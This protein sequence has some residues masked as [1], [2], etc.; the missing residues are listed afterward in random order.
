MVETGWKRDRK[1]RQGC[2]V[3]VGGRD[4]TFYNAVDC[5]NGGEQ[6]FIVI[7]PATLHSPCVRC[8]AALHRGPAAWV[9]VGWLLLVAGFGFAQ[10]A[11]PL[12]P[13]VPLLVA[14]TEA[15]AGTT[16]VLVSA[17]RRAQELG[18]SSVA[19][20]LYQR[21]LAEP[22]ADRATLALGLA[23]ALIES[24]RPDDAEKAL[25]DSPAPRGSAWHLRVG[26]AA[27]QLRKYDVAR[28][29]AALVKEEELAADDRPWHLFLQGALFDVAP[30]QD[31]QRA[32]D[33]YNRAEAAATNELA[34]ARFQLAAEE[35]RLR[36]GTVKAEDLKR[37]LDSYEA[38]QGR[39]IGYPYAMSYAMSLDALGRN[40]EAQTF[41]QLVLATLPAQERD[42]WDKVRLVLGLVGGRGQS[43]AARR[44]LNELL[45]GGHDPL[46]QRQALQILSEASKVEPG[47]S[48][49]RIELDRLISSAPTHAIRESLLFYRAQLALM[50]KNDAKVIECATALL[51][52]FPTS[53]LR[54]H[55]Y[56]LLTQLAW[57]Q[58]RYRLAAD[59]ARKARAEMATAG[60]P[61][62][63]A[64]RAG[65]A[66]VEAEAWFRAGMNDGDKNMFRNAAEAYAVALRERPTN[67]NGG[68][69]MFQ[70]VLAE[71]KSGSPDAAKVL[72]EL[73]ND[74]AFDLENRWQAE[75]S[76][77]RA[78]QVQGRV[79]EAYAR[80]NALLG[81]AA[82]GGQPVPVKPDLRVRMAWLQARLSLQA[83]QPETTLSL[84]DLLLNTTDG[85]PSALR[86]E[87][88]S[89]ALLQKAGAQFELGREVP[90]LE[91]LA[92]VR[93]NFP[94][95]EA[96]IHS[97]LIEADYYADQGKIVE[98]QKRLTSLTD[99]ESYK[100]NRLIPYAYYQLALWSERLGQNKDFQDAYR[101]IENLVSTSAAEKEGDFVFV[102]RLKQAELLRRL[103]QFPQAQRVYDDLTNKP[104]STENGIIARLELAK[105]HNAQAS[106]DPSHGD[107][108]KLLF[109]ELRDRVDAPKDV[110]V[111]A[112]YHLA[113][114]LAGRGKLDDAV[115]VWWADV[116][117]PYLVEE[118][119][120]FEPAA[121]RPY[122]LARTLLDLGLL[123]EQQGKL[124]EAR[125]AYD[126]IL[127]SK[128]GSGEEL[129]KKGLERMGGRSG[130]R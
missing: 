32:N 123:L 22:D 99:D 69:L 51:E 82:A 58:H 68:D 52:Q 28:A 63:I 65:L 90:A 35:V 108:A 56:G 61:R 115:K 4:V 84:V 55:T 36:R 105:C 57:E 72:D 87:I 118:K 13:P 27:L 9:R 71:I 119:P 40:S 42:S 41:L 110:R 79:A 128:L 49:L 83:G 114:L 88:A 59:N 103:N 50:E 54:G 96:V 1:R 7:V 11:E 97:Y 73:D 80:V 124:D 64:A 21:V 45:A 67:V 31:R 74:P 34:R 75:W 85:V 30:V 107:S 92:K 86:T 60:A 3:D 25:R 14:R 104:A 37:I 16:T 26:L 91:T 94:K 24:A 102:A 109:E 46:R 111:E 130:N 12:N 18:L 2:R 127:R 76:L 93:A 98:A 112:G 95:S 101:Y 15:S 48:Q 129:A 106:A 39:G 120:P 70:R 53:T 44:A 78:L 17:A 6:L 77:A 121:K 8:R 62:D 125:D 19:I 47:R 66:V 20:G 5:F 122:W 100:D 89:M 10:Q 81:A 38:N 113:A 29:E 33:F 43:L 117:T 116:I 23:T 126:L